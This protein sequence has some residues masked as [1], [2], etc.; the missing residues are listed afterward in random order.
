M[1]YNKLNKS[2]R[3]D[4][5]MIVKHKLAFITGTAIAGATLYSLIRHKQERDQDKVRRHLSDTLTKKFDNSELYGYW[6]DF[7]QNEDGQ[8]IG[9]I[10]LLDDDNH[11]IKSY[12]FTFD[13]AND[14]INNIKLLNTESIN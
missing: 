1:L 7:N 8:F 14:E 9:G 13:L 3:R 4:A 10:N 6:I 11:N 12:G 5:F 2:N